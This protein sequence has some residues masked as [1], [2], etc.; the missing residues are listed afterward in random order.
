MSESICPFCGKTNSIEAEFCWSCRA[1][2]VPAT[3][4]SHP[5][6][7]A[8]PEELASWLKQTG[9][10]NAASQQPQPPPEEV[11]EWLTRV[12]ERARLEKEAQENVSDLIPDESHEAE[13]STPDW[14][15][16]FRIESQESDT[17]PFKEETQFF[18]EEEIHTEDSGSTQINQPEPG[19][20]QSEGSEP[21]DWINQEEKFPDIPPGATDSPENTQSESLVQQPIQPAEPEKP[22]AEEQAEQTVRPAPE[23]QSPVFA[24]PFNTDE[25][26]KMFISVDEN[27]PEESRPEEPT[28]PPSDRLQLPDWLK[29]LESA[30]P[31]E[32]AA[33]EQPA[34]GGQHP[35]EPSLPASQP[36][37]SDQNNPSWINKAWPGD[38]SNLGH[39][40]GADQGVQPPTEP[41]GDV[42]APFA[43][44]D[45]PDWLKH[46]EKITPDSSAPLPAEKESSAEDHLEPATLPPWLKSMRPLESVVPE[47]LP[48]IPEG[49]EESQG[50]LAGIADALP[51]HTLPREFAKP[52]VYT[53]GLRIS[54]R[55]RLHAQVLESVFKPSATLKPEE[56]TIGKD[57]N[58]FWRI[59]ISILMIAV[60]F[61]KIV[62]TN[63]SL[64]P[65]PQMYPS[66]VIAT[67]NYLLSL[68]ED[69]LVLLVADFDAS[70]SGEMRIASQAV[71]EQL[72]VKQTRLAVLSTRPNG[73]VL[74]QNL[75]VN[76]QI[77]HPDYALDGKVVNLGYLAGGALGL[78]N[79][80]R[81]PSFSFQ[82]TTAL[83]SPILGG[84][85]DWNHFN[86]M[87]I[88][89]DSIENARLWVEQ[90][91]PSIPFLPAY[92]VSSAQAAP[93]LS[94]YID[95]GQIKGLIAG[96]EGG[97]LL[98]QQLNQ[99]SSIQSLWDPYQIGILFLIVFIILGGIIQAIASR[100][101]KPQ[102]KPEETDHAVD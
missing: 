73:S 40:S 4:G 63:I 44:E 23:N 1:R 102:E 65:L 79:F 12:R 72:M 11:P 41:P 77:N 97:T 20:I 85:M 64:T 90:V 19:Q 76:A 42:H 6:Q 14:L 82:N 84:G 30:V 15:K 62:F 10:Q 29:E 49:G 75:L 57:R 80:A 28:P 2:L 94:P 86:G 34:A 22:P 52:P 26:R 55:Q 27:P 21:G 92:M 47:N 32:P 66:G 45:L 48:V 46:G 13:S 100:P 71:L 99:A 81:I 3:H 24:K 53:G 93:V 101:E 68:P 33:L 39:P 83:S 8:T 91:T 5:G 89:T 98:S 60:L 36:A 9:D 69:S 61:G 43:A 54:D 17:P 96:L 37:F 16:E 18:A 95:S 87:I 50:P 70:L 38:S 31:P 56:K 51:G 78:Q 35:E 25:L 74:A 7:N 59:L 88:L 58:K 67:R